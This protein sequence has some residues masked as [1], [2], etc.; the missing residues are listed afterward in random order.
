MK[1]VQSLSDL[2]SIWANDESLKNRYQSTDVMHIVGAD[3]FG[4]FSPIY[5]DYICTDH[6][7]YNSM[8]LAEIARK[9]M[10]LAKEIFKTYVLEKIEKEG[11]TE[12]NFWAFMTN[13][14]RNV[15]KID[16]DYVFLRGTEHPVLCANCGKL[17]IDEDE[18]VADYYNMQFCTESCKEDYACE[19]YR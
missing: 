19:N 7:Y 10:K 2:V 16:G 11:F 8:A 15:N 5:T 18:A 3:L 4:Y 9:D 17:I 1:S 13:A 14:L 6:L 12:D